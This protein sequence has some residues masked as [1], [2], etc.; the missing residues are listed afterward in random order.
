MKIVVWGTGRE[1]NHRIEALE[2]DDVLCFIDSNVE[3]QGREE[4]GKKICSPKEIQEIQFD[5]VLISTSRYFREIANHL[6]FLYGIDTRKII[7]WEYY[8]TITNKKNSKNTSVLMERVQT[9]CKQCGISQILD[10]DGLIT[11]K[12]FWGK[13]ISI[14]VDG[15]SNNYT[16]HIVSNAQY[17]NVWKSI[18]DVK[19]NYEL[20]ILLRMEGITGGLIQKVLQISDY[21]L[22]YATVDNQKLVDINKQIS[23]SVINMDGVLLYLFSKHEKEISLYQVTHK[24]FIAVGDCI[25]QPIHAGKT[26]GE[27][28]GYA[29][30]NV[31]DN[32]SCLNQKVNECTALYWMWKNVHTSYIGL[33]HYRR[34][35]QSQMNKQWMLQDGE[36]QMILNSTD[37]LV[38]EPVYFPNQTVW[39][40]LKGQVCEEAFDK[41]FYAL[42]EI[43]EK[44]DE[45]DKEIFH[46]VFHGHM[47]YP[48][49]MFITSKQIVDQYCE[50]LFPIVFELIDMVEI[51]EMWDD[52]SKRIIG[53][54]AERLFTVWI[55]EQ[56]YQVKALSILLVGEDGPYGKC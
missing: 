22:L 28:I 36:I 55:M 31:G 15:I 52:Y 6:V 51:S 29:G 44:K 12:L 39:E 11:E 2:L 10:V 19:K 3:H 7:S 27:D 37:I 40:V 38:A 5:Y 46:Y 49:N 23:A 18:D 17:E 20:A 41:A 25:Y 24:K 54:L 26:N 30:D 1:L 35:F 47:M 42:E 33:N 48:C 50:W 14:K 43:F 13:H 56:N 9:L 8:Y 21:L 16:N 4:F 32:I 53:F 34:L 45:K